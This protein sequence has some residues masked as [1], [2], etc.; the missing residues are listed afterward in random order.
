M[1]PP[2]SPDDALLSLEP[3][4]RLIQ[5]VHGELA[6]SFDRPRAIRIA[7]APGRLDVMGGIADYTGSLVCEATLQHAAAVAVQARDDRMVQVL[8]FNLLDEQKPF[9]L[10]ITLDQLAR[11]SADALRGDLANPARRWAGYLIGCLYLLHEQRHLDLANPRHHGVNLA[12]LSTVPL[13]AGVSSSAAIEV[14]TMMALVDHYLSPPAARP[15]PLALAALCQQ[16]ENR[17]VGAPCGI[18]DQVACTLGREHELLKI[19]CQP[20]EVQGSLALPQGVQVLGINSGVRHSV[21]GGMYG[22]TRCAAFMAHSIILRKMSELAAA[23]GREMCGDPMRGYLANL[24]QDDYKRYFRPY[25]PEFTTGREFLDQFGPTI[26]TATS[27]DPDTRYHVQQAAD[28][29]VIEARRVRQFVRFI[30][31]AAA[32]PPNTREQGL[33]LDK[34]GHLMYASHISYTNDALLGADEC[35][36]LVKLL[37]DREKAGIYG[38]KITGGGAG[39]TVAVLCNQTPRVDEALAEVAELYQQRTGR[40]AELIRGTSPGAWHVGTALLRPGM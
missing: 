26:D 6:G 31:E 21:G 32:A 2:P 11:T 25:L 17:I 37:R 39:G 34:A 23:A 8:S 29:H 35:D 19:H 1:N 9:T 12:L 36:L 20:H 13:G 24:H 18:M 5:R 30:E 38:A 33:P 15:D 28:H 40:R 16:V 22:I 10:S 7:R 27:V 4:P 14:A 3:V